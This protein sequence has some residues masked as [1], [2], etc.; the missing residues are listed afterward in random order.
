MLKTA[1]EQA[2]TQMQQQPS[3]T[4]AT[5]NGYSQV[6]FTL[7]SGYK[8]QVSAVS[9]WNG[10]TFVSYFNGTTTT[11]SGCTPNSAQLLTITVTNANVNPSQTSSL[12]TVVADPN[13]RSVQ[14]TTTG[15]PTSIIFVQQ[16]TDTINGSAISPPPVIAFLVGTSVLLHHTAQ[17]R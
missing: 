3:A 8:A 1:V 2:T 12:S 17:L 11:P 4:W 6:V 13:A 5:C 9:V 14:T 15:T 10:S 16:P 7:P